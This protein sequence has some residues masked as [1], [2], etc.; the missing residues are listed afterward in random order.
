MQCGSAFCQNFKNGDSWYLYK[1]SYSLVTIEP[2]WAGSSLDCVDKISYFHEAKE[3]LNLFIISEYIYAESGVIFMSGVWYW[4]YN[5]AYN[6]L[7]G[8][9]GP[10]NM[11]RVPEP[12]TL[13]CRSTIW[14]T[15][16]WCLT[17]LGEGGGGRKGDGGHSQTDRCMVP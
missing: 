1:Y 3:Y 12:R 7:R 8:G 5:G 15:K 16:P 9:V 2:N 10:G 6:T 4:N 17:S 11:T 13:R 14:T